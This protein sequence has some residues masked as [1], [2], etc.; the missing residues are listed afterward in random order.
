[1]VFTGTQRIISPNPK[2]TYCVL[3]AAEAINKYQVATTTGYVADSSNVFHKSI[4]AGISI[5]DIESLHSGKVVFEGEVENENWTWTRGDV[6]YLN[7]TTISTTP[8]T[9][10]FIVTLGSAISP[11]R[12]L[13][14]ISVSILL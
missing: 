2:Q 6:L 11:F 12:V 7:G 13:V 9:T 10:G 1:M 3:V 4:I 5:D 14:N 8:P